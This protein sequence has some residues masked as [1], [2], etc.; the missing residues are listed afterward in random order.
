[1]ALRPDPKQHFRCF[2][3]PHNEDF[4]CGKFTAMFSWQQVVAFSQPLTAE[5]FEN[6]KTDIGDNDR[7]VT[8]RVMGNVSVIVF[9]KETAK[10]RAVPMRWG[11]P[12]PSD[13]R[14][15]QPIH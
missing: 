5:S 2:L 10:R 3:P 4:V 9:D 6:K 12:H 1:M 11:F 15:P 7:E 8:L 13:W 14:R